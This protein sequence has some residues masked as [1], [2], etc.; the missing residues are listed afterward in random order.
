MKNLHKLLKKEYVSTNHVCFEKDISCGACQAG[1]QV[2]AIHHVENIM[3]TS[4]PLELLRMELFS[5]IA[6][7]IISVSM[8]LLLLMTIHSSLHYSFCRTKVKP[9][10]C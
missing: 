4:R 6:Y 1:K 10:A 2:D 7:I 9:K 3:T 8:I 5:P